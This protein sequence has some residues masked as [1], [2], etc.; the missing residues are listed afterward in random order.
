MR[1]ISNFI[2]I[3]LLVLYIP[4][5]LAAPIGPRS[6]AQTLETRGQ[7]TS[8]SETQPAPP[9]NDP[10]KSRLASTHPTYGATSNTLPNSNDKSKTPRKSRF[11]AGLRKLFGIKPKAK[12]DDKSPPVA[13]SPSVA[14][15]QSV[16]SS[17]SGASTAMYTPV[18]TFDSKSDS[19]HITAQLIS[20]LADAR[21]TV[22]RLEKML[23]EGPNTLFPSSSSTM[24]NDPPPELPK[25]GLNG[26][27]ET[28][29]W[30]ARF[31]KW[32]KR[33]WDE[34]PSWVE[35]PWD[36][37][38]DEL[39]PNDPNVYVNQ[40]TGALALAP[41]KDPAS[42]MVDIELWS[43]KV[44]VARLEVDVAEKAFKAVAELTAEQMTEEDKEALFVERGYQYIE[45]VE[46]YKAMWEK[47]PR[48]CALVDPGTMVARDDWETSEVSR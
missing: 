48:L 16:A 12:A 19:P 29:G 22:E 39:D 41:P 25:G 3:A 31:R 30:W 37:M 4:A 36:F 15:S 27:P 44:K 34:G 32:L 11:R 45:K 7:S 6:M 35:P 14:K 8:K 10:E 2:A 17:Q 20:D 21:D 26:K 42:V 13:K 5:A 47:R 18:S 43:A 23:K 33:M 9:S 46:A 28:K 1:L 40:M 38:P 24:V